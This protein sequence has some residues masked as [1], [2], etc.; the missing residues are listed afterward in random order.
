MKKLT[1]VQFRPA[2]L[3][4]IPKM[5]AII[6]EHAKNGLMLRKQY[7]GMLELLP[8]FFVAEFKGEIIGTCAFKIWLTK[9][10]E[11]IS[12]AV[13]EIYHGRGIGIILN[14][15]VIQA[16]RKLGFTNFFVL[17]KQPTFYAKLGFYEI[18]KQQLSHK[19]YLDCLR[20]KENINGDADFF[21]TDKCRDVAMYRK[22]P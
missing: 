16:A 22:V 19:L 18:P 15:K 10:I 2:R 13:I 12:S 8:N 7:G 21:L 14:N 3:E 11:I 5:L 9:E 6:N 17:T 4:D 1:G 20:C